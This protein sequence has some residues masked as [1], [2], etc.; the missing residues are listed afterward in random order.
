MSKADGNILEDHNLFINDKLFTSSGDP[1][2]R[3]MMSN[4][5]RIWND[6]ETHSKCNFCAVNHVYALNI[7]FLVIMDKFYGE[8]EQNYETNDT[9]SCHRNLKQY[10]LGLFT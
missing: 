3:F 4:V 9:T 5:I 7:K 8:S 2:T 1:C 6:E 10:I